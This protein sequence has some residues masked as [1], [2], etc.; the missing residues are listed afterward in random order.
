MKFLNF[1]IILVMFFFMIGCNKKN[2]IET[3]NNNTPIYS[4]NETISI[5]E[6]D[7]IYEIFNCGFGGSALFEYL[8]QKGIKTYRLANYEESFLYTA[9]NVEETDIL[10]IFLGKSDGDYVVS[11]LLLKNKELMY[12][13]EEFDKL[14]IGQSK[15][16]D[17]IK[18][19]KNTKY[20]TL[21][22]S[23]IGTIT[24]HFLK[25]DVILQ[26]FYTT[27]SLHQITHIKHD[28]RENSVG[29]I[30]GINDIDW[31]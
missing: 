27:N 10:Y 8:T 15:I 13:N 22:T 5:V 3:F 2:N 18:I 25:N 24:T 1:I 21:H 6:L 29:Y 26:V 4:E 7:E 9:I 14:K 17:V 28:K 11:H 19:D 23:S 30:Q 20:N 12:N 31:Y 16:E